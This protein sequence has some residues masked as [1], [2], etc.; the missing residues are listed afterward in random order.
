M[1]GAGV[2]PLF[3][4]TEPENVHA[5]IGQQ[6]VSS[7]GAGFAV[8]GVNVPEVIW[9]SALHRM[10]RSLLGSSIPPCTGPVGLP[11]PPSSP[12]PPP[13]PHPAVAA[14]TAN[15]TLGPTSRIMVS[16]RCN[17]NASWQ[18]AGFSSKPGQNAPSLAP[19]GVPPW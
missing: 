4:A 14:I 19:L 16:S 18:V 13:T 6:P 9:R 12:P 2:Q 15:R 17:V 8:S 5:P 3:C 7:G 1:V 10:P 11:P